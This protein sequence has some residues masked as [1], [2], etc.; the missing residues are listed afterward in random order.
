M[1]LDAGFDGGVY[2]PGGASRI[3]NGIDTDTVGDWVRNDF[4]G[5]GLPGFIDTL[6]PGNALNTPSA[7]NAIPEP[8]TVALL[9]LGALP[10]VLRKRR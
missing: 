7:V 4:G 5:I 9:A 1:V 3:P 6:D 10:L 2:I 8:G